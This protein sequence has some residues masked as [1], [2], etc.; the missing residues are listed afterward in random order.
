[1]EGKCGVRRDEDVKNKLQHIK[2]TF[3]AFVNMGFHMVGKQGLR[4]SVV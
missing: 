2:D 4:V 3:N 1:M